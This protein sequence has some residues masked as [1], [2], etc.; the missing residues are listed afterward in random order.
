MDILEFAAQSSFL[1][2][3]S[4]HCACDPA[5]NCEVMS[6]PF[7]RFHPPSF[8][9]M[10][11]AKESQYA[12]WPE[13]LDPIPGGAVHTAALG[14]DV[15]DPAPEQNGNV[16]LEPAPTRPE[17]GA[18]ARTT[19]HPPEPRLGSGLDAGFAA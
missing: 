4:L 12:F 7:G 3:L 8:A 9:M 17:P 2:Y 13:N 1:P 14:H 19:Q 6:S 10:P 11:P 18:D 15:G 16:P 5:R